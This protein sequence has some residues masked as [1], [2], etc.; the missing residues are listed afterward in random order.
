LLDLHH[1]LDGHHLADRPRDVAVDDHGLVGHARPAAT[2]ATIAAAPLAL[3]A[4]R[5]R[6]V[7]GNQQSQ[8]RQ[9]HHPVFHV[10]PLPSPQYDQANWA[11]WDT[12]VVKVATEE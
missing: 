2:A 12:C 8:G 10:A 5:R 9:A 4:R 6:G 1:L 3:A 7:D 11:Y